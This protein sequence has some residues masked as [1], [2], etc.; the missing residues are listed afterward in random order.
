MSSVNNAVNDLI[1]DRGEFSL[2]E[3]D[4]DLIDCWKNGILFCDCALD[5]MD[6]LFPIQ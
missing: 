3:N 6:E 2:R 1:A 5:A 4:V